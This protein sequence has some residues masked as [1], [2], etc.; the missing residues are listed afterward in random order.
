LDT[1]LDSQSDTLIAPVAGSFR[2]PSGRVFTSDGVIYR[3][4]NEF[5]RE[6]Y[7]RFVRSGLAE[8]LTERGLI[9]PFEEVPF[10]HAIAAGAYKVLR[11]E[12]VPFISYPYEWSFSQ[13]RDAALLTLRVH[14]RALKF[15][16][17][18]KDASAYNI[19]F[20]R[21]KPV[22]IDTLSFERDVPGRPWVAYRQFCQHFLAP[23]AL[24]A[25][26]DVRLGQLLRVFLDGVPLD[27]ASR[28]LPR[29]TLL[30][31]SLA[32]HVHLHAYFQ[33]RYG[34]GSSGGS[35]RRGAVTSDRRAQLL[36][37]LSDAVLGLKWTPPRT[38]WNDYYNHTNYSQQAF[39]DKE[40]VVTQMLEALRPA[41]VWDLG[42]NVGHFSR[43]ASRNGSLTMAFDGDPAVVDASYNDAVRRG[44]PYL[45]PLLVDL[46][47]PSASIGWAGSERLSLEQRG[48]ADTVL[49]LALIHH[50]AISN[51]V[52]L[53]KIAEWLSG[54]SATL[55]IEFVPKADAQVQR[56]LAS[57]VDVFDDYGRDGFEKAFAARFAIDR[58]CEIPGT[59]RLLYQ[60]RRHS[61]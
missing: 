52:P 42:A 53:P 54:L 48:P 38:E 13:L 26:R 22:L 9:T 56:L 61:S 55:I 10:P 29:R 6:D 41:V 20:V 59:G 14:K 44:D 40:R 49:A 7:D 50:L 46:T 45:L 5:Y 18:L 60:M 15:G 58:T 1:Y 16:M 24:M 31:P 32:M 51:N 4:I 27:L 3:Q 19:Q 17:S 21:G 23:L 2:D 28:L 36:E 12:R 33:K 47:N 11:P 43:I 39:A 34:D 37:S 35:S 30:K 57:R 25:A 8:D